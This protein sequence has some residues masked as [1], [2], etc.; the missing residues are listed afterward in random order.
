MH[1]MAVF[2]ILFNF[3]TNTT[4]LYAVLVVFLLCWT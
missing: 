1:E 3:L 2:A 4:K